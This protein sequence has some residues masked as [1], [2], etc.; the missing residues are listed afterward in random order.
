MIGVNVIVS[1]PRNVAD[2]SPGRGGTGG[3]YLHEA[4]ASFD[5]SAGGQALLGVL[6]G[7]LP[8]EAVRF[9]NMLRFLHDVES[10]RGGGLHPVGQFK[11]LQAGPQVVFERALLGVLLVQVAQGIEEGALPWIVQ[12]LGALEV[13]DGVGGYRVEGGGLI[14]GGKKA[15]GPDGTAAP[16]LGAMHHDVGRQVA[17]LAAQAIGDP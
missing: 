10:L 7:L 8:F 11:G 2:A 3:E 9:A 14:D 16:R 13:G 17:V 5:E 1:V 4:H 12:M 15:T 6:L